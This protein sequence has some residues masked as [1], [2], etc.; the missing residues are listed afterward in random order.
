MPLR[1]G[2]KVFGLIALANKPGGYTQADQEAV[3]SLSAAIVEGLMRFRAEARVAIVS[4][5]YRLLSQVNEAIVRARDQAALFQEICRI[6]VEEGGFK[7]AWVGMVDAQADI[8]RAVAQYGIEEGYLER[9]TISLREGAESLGPTG[10]A[11]REDRSDICNDIAN[12]PRMAPWREEALT[13]GYRS[14]GSF[15]LRV[16]GKVVG[17]LTMYAGEPGF[18]TDEEVRLL[19]S[20]AQ[21]VSFA[22]ESLE[23]DARR[24]QT[25]AALKASEERL[26]DLTSRLINAQEAERK[27]L[28][29]ELHDD[30]GQSLMVL[31]LQVRQ[32]EKK[33][34]G[35]QRQIREYCTQ[36]LN[37]INE[38]VENVRRLSRDLRPPVLQDLGLGV[39]VQLILDNFAK[40]HDLECFWEIDDIRGLLAAE[41]EVMIY[42]IFQESL[43][44]ISRHAHATR[45]KVAIRKSPGP[46]GSVLRIMES[47]LISRTFPAKIFW[48]RVW[49]WP[50]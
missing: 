28:A 27:R 8:V 9:I 30:L 3:E 16:G 34:P 11:V 24:R 46:S 7:M 18:F 31:K 20:L 40:L 33:V 22:M 32:I 10:T 21:D 29:I 39:A 47:A 43:T 45:V 5:L 41:Q 15:P 19:E 38:V 6:A 12:D 35:D 14:S 37:Y 42:R 4:R 17:S 36:V 26:R 50:P 25:E 48:K 13:R 23:R 44:N 1:H 49:V 2:G